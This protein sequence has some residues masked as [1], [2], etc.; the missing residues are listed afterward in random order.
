MLVI[1]RLD[2]AGIANARMNAPEEVWNHAQ[3][4]ARHRWREVDSPVG[5][6]PATLPPA[7]FAGMEA[8]MDPIPAVGEHSER[9]LRELGYE[10][11]EISALK[12]DGAI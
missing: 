6:I 8:R 9:I 5:R 1:E 2:A 12:A 4:R 7:S 11:G 10:A 3:L